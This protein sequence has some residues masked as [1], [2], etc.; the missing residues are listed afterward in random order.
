MYDG[1]ARTNDVLQILPKVADITEA[2]RQ[3]IIAESRFLRGHFHFELKKMYNMVPY[4]D[5]TT[6]DPNNLESTKVPN[7]E[8]IWPRIVLDLQAAYTALPA[9]QAQPGRPTKWARRYPGKSVSL[10]AKI[11]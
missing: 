10:P 5:E 2:A 6:Y 1:I 3:E 9:K 8:D 11:Q 4:I 7:S